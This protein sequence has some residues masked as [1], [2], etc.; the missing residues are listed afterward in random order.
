MVKLK[1]EVENLTNDYEHKVLELPCDL[2]TELMDGCEYVIVSQ[3]EFENGEIRCCGND[4]VRFNQALLDINDQ[5]PEMTT[6][7][8]AMILGATGEDLSDD[9]TVRRIC[10]NDFGFEDLSSIDWRMS[11]EEICACYLATI[12]G[13]KFDKDMADSVFASLC[14]D[15]AVDYIVW[16]DVWRQYTFLGYEM[17]SATNENGESV[18]YLIYWK[19]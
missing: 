11:D 2:K 5:N 14:D 1:V 12:L 9:E 6:E 7:L 18:R 17:I 4:I 16:S 19:R 3:E 10:E 15:S 8:L 13:V